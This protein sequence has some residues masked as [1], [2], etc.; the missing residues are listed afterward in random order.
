MFYNCTSL[1]ALEL[2]E[3]INSNVNNMRSMFSGCSELTSLDLQTLN[4]QK[5]ADIFEIF[6]NCEK[7]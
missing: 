3:F 4:I 6:K 1:S 5:E 2:G 7:I